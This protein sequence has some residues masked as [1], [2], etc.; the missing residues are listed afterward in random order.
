MQIKNPIMKIIIATG[1]KDIMKFFIFGSW[2]NIRGNQSFSTAEL[3]WLQGNVKGNFSDFWK[4]VLPLRTFT[5]AMVP[6]YSV[7]PLQESI[8][9]LFDFSLKVVLM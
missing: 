7:V 5:N 9:E 8:S 2:I 6:V 1:S 3:H 4:W